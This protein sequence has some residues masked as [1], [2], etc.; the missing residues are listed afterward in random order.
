MTDALGA[1]ARLGQV[2]LNLL[3]N[4][5]QAIPEGHLAEHEIRLVTRTDASGR[6]VLEVRDTGVGIPADIADRIFDPFFTTKPT[7]V[8]TG[9]GLS[10][11]RS[12]VL[13][14][15]GEIRAESRPGAGT[16]LRVSL[17]AAPAA[18]GEVEPSPPPAS[19]C[20]RGRVL[21]VDD[22]PAV[23]AA[24]KRVLASQHEVTVRGSGEEALEAIARG[25]RFDAIVCDLMM[26]RMTGMDLHAS[27]AR[28]APEQASRIVVLT[29]GAFTDRAREFL[30]HVPLP[31]CEKPFDVQGLRD[32]VRKV[33]G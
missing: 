9:L 26:P 2:V 8:G 4:A 22:E 29:G 16:T 31:R 7:G 19:T 13:A 28:L 25:E 24:I 15:G 33:V 30:E 21:V 27:L 17:P 1:L 23:A 10:I 12:I 3:I 14:L 6:A 5:A 18:A 32:L 20:R 11:C